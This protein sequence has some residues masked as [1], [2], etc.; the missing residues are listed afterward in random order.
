MD[1]RRRKRRRSDDESKPEVVFLESR[2]LHP[3]Q[4]S[5]ITP[6]E[7]LTLPPILSPWINHSSTEMLS[8]IVT[9][10]QYWVGTDFPLFNPLE[11]SYALHSA[12]QINNTTLQASSSG[13]P[14]TINET[15][16][17]FRQQGEL[18]LPEDTPQYTPMLFDRQQT[19]GPTFE[20]MEGVSSESYYVEGS[21]VNSSAEIDNTQRSTRS[22]S[23]SKIEVGAAEDL[24]CYGMVVGFHGNYTKPS[25]QQDQ[26]EFPVTIESSHKFT[27]ASNTDLHGTFSSEF[28]DIM[29]ALLDVPSLKF[30]ATCTV[31]DIPSQSAMKT[32]RLGPV[33]VPCAL[34]V[35]VY[36]PRD[37]CENVGD[38]FQ[39]ID[40]YLQDPK[41]CDLDV[42]YCNPHRLSSLNIDECPMTSDLAASVMHLDTALFE[43]VSRETGLL[44]IFDSSQNL[45]ETPQPQAILSCLKKHQKQALTFLLQREA[46]WN[47]DPRSADFWDL[48]QTSQAICFINRI[49]KSCHSNEP[50]EFRGG[51]VAD[52]MG[53][54]KT[55][56]M[57]SLIAT[58]KGQVVH[59]QISPISTLR[60]M[61]SLI[62]VP[63]PLLDTWEEQLS[64]HVKRG[65]ITWRRHYGKERLSETDHLTQ[66]DIILSTYH[67]VTADWG[68]GQRA[69][70]STVFSTMWK[71]I[72]LD[73]AHVIRNTQSQ[74]SKAVCA[75][76]AA[77]RWAV[78]GTPVQNRIGDLAALLKFI[79]A[80]PYDEAKRFESDIGQMWKTG[81]IQEAARRLKDLSSGLILRR[82]KT[83]IDLPPRKDLKFRVD[84]SPDER[85]FY[86]KLRHQAITR[87]EEAFSD[88]D[89]GSASDSYITVIQKINA[90][91][92]V[93]NLGLH[94]DARHDLAAKEESAN[95][96][97]DWSTNVQQTFDFQREMD[98]VQCSNCHASCDMMATTLDT[99]SLVQPYFASC[100]SFLCSDCVQRWKRLNKPITCPHGSSHPIAPVNLNWTA[101]EESLRSSGNSGVTSTTPTQ[102]SSKVTALV[103]QLG[104]LPA[105]VKSVVFTSWRMTLD[106]VAIGLDQAR[107][108]YVRFDGNVPQKQRSS[109]IET[110]KKDPSVTVFLLTL[111]CGAVGW[112]FVPCI[113][114]HPTNVCPHRLTLTEASRAFLI[115]PHWNPTLEEQAL[116][117]VHR[118]GQQREVTTV[119]FFVKDTFEERVLDVQKS[120][121]KL[122]EVLL[123][124][125][126]ERGLDDSLSCLE[127]L[128]SLV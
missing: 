118:L 124:P 67:T 23:A 9:D 78:T 14:T 5:S 40:M 115:E 94:Y 31:D 68:G 20:T 87:M 16:N 59:N 121:K 109:V 79:R 66:W 60:S 96:S 106:L 99:E 58:D 90:L 53:L 92:M 64:Q 70:S 1:P 36:G 114:R 17:L 27:A 104:S 38:F 116:A 54:G 76:D 21:P 98:S 2:A 113:K 12:V 82:P 127:G 81:D 26:G 29:E 35:I 125:K 30:Q 33:S 19:R 100:L 8:P 49:S 69:G 13:A 117:R 93:C 71:R 103:S 73:E 85:K 28:V 41:R 120:K 77:A 88:G 63:P 57:I 7:G 112:A 111:S 48:R 39:D 42:K 65:E 34:S 108:R 51:I 6:T 4:R 55:L 61:P 15:T 122:E 74:M 32:S 83:V 44:D 102:L 123:V 119:R 62:L 105:G 95:H 47:L 84:F 50:P 80:H 24:V 128:R 3:I 46:G 97:K 11:N 110:F 56:T 52:P 37:M 86:D 89:G 10:P 75:L 43:D 25:W 101:L 72:I 91:R 126:G 45:P 22:S 18:T 107:I